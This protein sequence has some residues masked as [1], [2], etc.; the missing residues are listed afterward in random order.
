MTERRD[1]VDGRTRTIRALLVCRCCHKA[2]QHFFT[3]DVVESSS[4]KQVSKF[5]VFTCERCRTE[6]IWG[7]EMDN[8]WTN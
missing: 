5:N 2:T 4:D 3:K 8:V 1:T 6:R 7:L